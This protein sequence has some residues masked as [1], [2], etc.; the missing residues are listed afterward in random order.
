MA[1]KLLPGIAARF[2]Q[3]NVTVSPS[4]FPNSGDAIARPLDK[5]ATLVLALVQRLYGRFLH[6]EVAENSIDHPASIYPDQA[7]PELNG[8]FGPVGAEESRF[9]RMR[10]HL[11]LD[12]FSKSV[13]SLYA[14]SKRVDFEWT[15]YGFSSF[16]DFA[17]NA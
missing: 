16:P 15:E 6:A 9:G 3:S 8:H 17:S 13:L 10:L 12:N 2:C 7:C 14:E 1:H 11:V 5:R 4:S